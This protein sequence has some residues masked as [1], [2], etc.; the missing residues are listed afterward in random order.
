MR[1]DTTPLRCIRCFCLDECDDGGSYAAVKYCE[2]EDCPLWLYRFGHNARRK[3]IGNKNA[4]FK[5]ATN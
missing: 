5:K 1:D 2:R 4:S 3:G